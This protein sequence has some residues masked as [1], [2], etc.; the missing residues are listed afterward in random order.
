V[1]GLVGMARAKRGEATNRGM[2]LAGTILGAVSLIMG[3]AL[4][5][6]TVHVVNSPEYDVYE[7]CDNRAVTTE[8]HDAC[9]ED[10]VNGL[11]G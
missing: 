10:L 1:F 2:A 6:L 8:Q 5:A 9:L 4:I 3:A 7:S 11:F